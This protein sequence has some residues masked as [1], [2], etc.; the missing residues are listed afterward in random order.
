MK[1]VN[2]SKWIAI[3]L[4]IIIVTQFVQVAFLGAA[5]FGIGGSADAG[6]DASRGSIAE[7]AYGALFEKVTGG[8]SMIMTAAA[9]NKSDAV[10]ASLTGCSPI[11]GALG[12][13]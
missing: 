3:A 1:N 4:S 12:A 5:K 11:E 6:S 13:T 10:I 2:W 8:E 7:E 9:E